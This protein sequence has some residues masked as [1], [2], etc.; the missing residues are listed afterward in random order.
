MV[1]EPW[2]EK[3]GNFSSGCGRMSAFG[4]QVACDC[5][6][7]PTGMDMVSH[8]D[9][10]VEHGWDNGRRYVWQCPECERSVCVNM[11]LV[12]EEE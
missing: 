9:G 4:M 8:W 12:G 2:R 1:E 7:H 11:K 6:G 5:S 3:N 10:D